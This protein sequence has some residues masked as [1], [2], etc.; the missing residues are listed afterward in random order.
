MRGAAVALRR[1]KEEWRWREEHTKTISMLESLLQIPSRHEERRGRGPDSP[2]CVGTTRGQPPSGMATCLD[3]RE[4]P[5]G[6]V[7]HVRLLEQNIH[8]R[9]DVERGQRHPGERRLGDFVVRM[10]CAFTGQVVRIGS[11]R[12]GRRRKRSTRGAASERALRTAEAAVAQVGT[13]T[14]FLRVPSASFLRG[15]VRGSVQAARRAHAYRR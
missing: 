15:C 1:R 9:A 2:P 4:R 5:L 10:L 11:G 6:A 14:T 12:A 7:H 13:Q 3:V 8:F